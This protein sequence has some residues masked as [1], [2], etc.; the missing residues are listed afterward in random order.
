[1]VSKGS[2]STKS[3]RIGSLNSLNA[4]A[5]SKSTSQDPLPLPTNILNKPHYGAHFDQSSQYVND[6]STFGW[7]HRLDARWPISLGLDWPNTSY[8]TYYEYENGRVYSHDS[9]KEVLIC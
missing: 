5:L 1:M 4:R 8:H 6:D 2:Q 7:D 3:I 9:G